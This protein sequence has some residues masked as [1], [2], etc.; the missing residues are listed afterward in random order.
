MGSQLTIFFEGDQWLIIG[1]HHEIRRLLHLALALL[2]FCLQKTR[3]KEK[4][5]PPFVNPIPTP[6]STTTT[7]ISSKPPQV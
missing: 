4:R 2:A 3:K 6:P 5:D 1:A 7:R